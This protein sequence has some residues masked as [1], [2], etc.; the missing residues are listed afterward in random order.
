VGLFALEWSAPM[1]RGTIRHPKTT[2]LMVELGVGRAEVLGILTMLWDFCGDYTPDGKVG[3]FSDSEIA[4]A[5]EWSK[6]PE[7]LIESL[8]KT[9]WIDKKSKIKT[10]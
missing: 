1:K 4:A 8:I 9:R 7:K 3:R 6:E 10:A 2:A 5:V